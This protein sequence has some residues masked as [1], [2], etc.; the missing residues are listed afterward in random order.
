MSHLASLLRA[1]TK[2]AS[3]PN[4]LLYEAQLERARVKILVKGEL[5]KGEDAVL[6][7]QPRVE[8]KEEEGLENVESGEEGGVEKSGSGK[9][10]AGKEEEEVKGGS[11]EKYEYGD[12]TKG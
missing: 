5:G 8:K 10:G 11:E 12:K 6:L 7:E 2:R 4:N 3:H 1:V 9:K